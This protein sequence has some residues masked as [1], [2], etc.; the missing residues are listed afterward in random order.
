MTTNDYSIRIFCGFGDYNF[1][2]KIGV[3]SAILFS[4]NSFA[5]Y[6]IKQPSDVNIV[7]YALNF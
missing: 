5:Y 2:N 4:K 3:K 7:L 6:P 1:T